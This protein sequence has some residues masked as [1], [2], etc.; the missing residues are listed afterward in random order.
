[1]NYDIKAGGPMDRK[2]KF[3]D[4]IGYSTISKGHKCRLFEV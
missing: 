4:E 2:K 3:R 1:M